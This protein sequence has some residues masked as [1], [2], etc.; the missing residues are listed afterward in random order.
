MKT[1]FLIPLISLLVV[2]V[3]A[4]MP[5]LHPGNMS[6]VVCAQTPDKT[7]GLALESVFS[8]VRAPENKT[9][10]L[11][12][13][14]FLDLVETSRSEL[15][16]ALVVDGTESMRD[17][18]DS[19]K[20][21]LGSMIDDLQLYKGPHVRLQIVVYRDNGAAQGEIEFP[22]KAAGRKFTADRK[23]LQA[24]VDQISA[25]AGAPY[26][27]ELIDLGIQSAITDLEWSD[28]EDTTKWLLVFGDAPPYLPD[29]TEPETGARRRVATDQL[30]GQ[31]N[32]K[33]IKVNCVLCTSR[34]EDRHAYEAVLDQLR[35]FMGS[36]SSETGGLMLDLSYPDL[37]EAIETAGK[38]PRVP[39]HEVSVITRADI[40]SVR[41][42]LSRAQSLL[43]QDRRLKIAILPHMPLE[44]MSFHADLPAVQLSTDLRQRLRRIPGVEIASSGLVRRQLESLV[45]RGVT[46]EALLQ[47][48]AAALKLDYVIWGS[49]ENDG[50]LVRIDSAI[51]DG[52]GGEAIV[53][54]TVRSNGPAF[55][56]SS[57]EIVRGLINKAIRTPNDAR[58]TSALAVL[59]TTP[60]VNGEL[61][62][63]VSNR[64]EVESSLLTGYELLEQ[65]LSE[66]AGS[67]ASQAGL[68][69]AEAALANA[70]G[71][72]GD[73][74]NGTGHM[75][76]ASCYLNQSAALAKQGN[77]EAA[78][79]RMQRFRAALNQAF[80]FR[81]R[82]PSETD[83]VEIEADFNLFIKKDI[84]A[85][86]KNYQLMA[87][88]SATATGPNNTNE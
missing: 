60:S 53:Q 35:D 55:G 87:K 78:N 77:A 15:E 79:E 45:S 24:A 68:A 27:P 21:T 37:R 16:I 31:A 50:Q 48:L 56:E 57:N 85:A 9:M 43:A 3:P 88:Q 58:L 12:Q 28:D 40:D 39:L 14:S 26:F 44:K 61:I 49:V 71:P 63:R 33:G 67:E 29:F 8:P 86:V 51:Y 10:G 17:S 34:E 25:D 84:A 72:N 22:L 76:L 19:I 23:S 82:V 13:R 30:I 64:P 54:N 18:L 66:L 65:A 1:G 36:L 47:A 20:R 7:V 6:G 5:L 32:A 69:E 75:L 59:R 70:V 2:G 42:E 4:Q 74:Q 46:G 83:R 41:D 52:I 62:T 11:T 38:Q 81:S 73:P 80:Q